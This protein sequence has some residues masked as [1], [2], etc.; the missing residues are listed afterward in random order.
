MLAIEVDGYAWHHDPD[1]KARDDARRNHLGELGWTLKVY[2]W[3]AV[4]RDPLA[5]ADE[6]FR[7][8]QRLSAAK[9]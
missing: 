4:T 3:R 8:Y 5:V 2:G 6:I 7:A 9:G 1:Q